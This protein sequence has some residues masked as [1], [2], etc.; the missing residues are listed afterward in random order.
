VTLCRPETR[1]AVVKVCDMVQE[2]QTK[3]VQYT[4]CV[5]QEQVYTCKKPQHVQVPYDYTVNLCRAEV[6]TRTVK[7]PQHIV[8]KATR[9]EQYTVCVP[10]TR[11]KVCN[12]TDYQ[13]VEEA[14][15]VAY[16][17]MVP[18]QVPKQVCYKLKQMV[19]KTITCRVP[20]CAPGGCGHAACGSCY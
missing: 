18:T 17:V 5:P 11:E 16:T 4:V 3:E 15:D 19:P 2:P 8:E 7:V 10:Q 9:E 14:R 13:C 12:V 20:V 6:R 1:T